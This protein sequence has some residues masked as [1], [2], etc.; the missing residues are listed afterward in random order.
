MGGEAEMAEEG[1]ATERRSIYPGTHALGWS[2]GSKMGIL[3]L[4]LCGGGV[5]RERVGEGGQGEVPYLLRRRLLGWCPPLSVV[6]WPPR[7]QG[8]RRQTPGLTS[9]A[10]G[11][12]VAWGN[13]TACSHVA[14]LVFALL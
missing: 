11:R 7:R 10:M 14:L 9:F 13:L 2:A 12:P 6:L 1:E 4:V 3:L 5:G 8:E